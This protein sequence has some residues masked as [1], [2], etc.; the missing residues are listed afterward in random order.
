MRD[1][2]RTNLC[3][4]ERCSG[5]VGKRDRNMADDVCIEGGCEK[6]ENKEINFC[7]TKK[8]P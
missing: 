2:G 5:Q 3:N 1:H 4:R 7:R 6:Y 8:L